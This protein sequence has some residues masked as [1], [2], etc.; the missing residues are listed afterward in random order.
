MYD[1]LAELHRRPEPFSR[2]TTDRLWTDPHIGRQMLAYHLDP[3]IDAASRK[4]STI[5]A[6]V[7]WIDRRFGLAG[8]RVLNLGCGPGLYASRMSARGADVTGLDFSP[9]SIARAAAH[10]PAGASLRYVE[11]NYLL[12]P[13]PAPADLVTLI[14]GDFCALSP[15]R[16]RAL[17]ANVAA[18]LAPGGR[19]VFDVFSPGQFA[20]IV[21]GTE[22]GHR[23]M[24]GFWSSEGYF[25]FKRTLLYPAEHISLERYLIVEAARSFEVFNW[26]QYNTPETIAAELAAA[27]FTADACVEIES[28][29]P[30]HGGATPFFVIARRAG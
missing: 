17:L 22:F 3:D 16:R 8:K 19:F 6:T 10:V 29:E 11:A 4:A 1:Q 27:G 25:G 23:Y 26:M 15:D 21:E 20:A 14:Y 5:E 30:W 24:G 12:P 9:V 28:G 2:Y 13:L 18:A 7:G